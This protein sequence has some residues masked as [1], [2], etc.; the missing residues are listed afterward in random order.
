MSKGRCRSL[1]GPGGKVSEKMFNN[2]A[3]RMTG[4]YEKAD[5]VAHEAF[6][7]ALGRSKVSWRSNPFHLNDQHRSQSRKKQPQKTRVISHYEPI[8][9]GQTAEPKD[10][11]LRL[12]GWGEEIICLINPFPAL[13]PP[14]QGQGLGQVPEP[15]G[16]LRALGEA[17]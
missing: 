1:W 9:V 2:I 15:V 13:A 3:F 6:F 12:R 5:E 11:I 10:M 16:L 14:E 4:D 8:S 17:S 7:P